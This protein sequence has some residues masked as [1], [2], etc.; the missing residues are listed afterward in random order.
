MK[1]LN[2]YRLKK[3]GYKVELRCYV[4]LKYN[5]IPKCLVF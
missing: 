1:T 4:K 5:K 2:Y 3:E